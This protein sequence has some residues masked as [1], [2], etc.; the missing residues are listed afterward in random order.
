M[1]RVRS[2]RPIAVADLVALTYELLDAHSDT[3]ELAASARDDLCWDAH[4]DYLRALQRNARELLARL[5]SAEDG[6]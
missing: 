1:K 2:S 6:Q 4:L 5:P 3:A